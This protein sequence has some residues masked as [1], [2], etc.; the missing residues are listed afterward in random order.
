M[1]FLRYA[2]ATNPQL[3]YGPCGAW[4]ARMDESAST[5]VSPFGVHRPVTKAPT[6]SERSSGLFCEACLVRW[7]C[8][9]AVGIA[10]RLSQREHGGHIAPWWYLPTKKREAC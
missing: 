7:P 2:E 9:V 5:R 4:E 3:R 10:V 8:L 6:I 1:P